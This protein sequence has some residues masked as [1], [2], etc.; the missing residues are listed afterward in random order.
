VTVFEN[1]EASGKT[2]R[3]TNCDLSLNH[4]IRPGAMPWADRFRAER[5]D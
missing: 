5:I 3:L 4:E 2:A 1:T